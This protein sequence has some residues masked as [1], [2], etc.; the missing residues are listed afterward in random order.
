MVGNGEKTTYTFLWIKCMVSHTGLLVYVLSDFYGVCSCTSRRDTEGTFGEGEHPPPVVYRRNKRWYCRSREVTV[1][2]RWTDGSAH[3]KCRRTPLPRAPERSVVSRV[4][5]PT[6]PDRQSVN[7]FSSSRSPADAGGPGLS[8]RVP[9]RSV[10][11]VS[12][13]RF[14]TV[15]RKCPN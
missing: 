9:Q 2:E 11:G 10:F 6:L 4:L 8:R 7:Q 15:E 1:P 5:G 14:S 13:H 3:E 12:V